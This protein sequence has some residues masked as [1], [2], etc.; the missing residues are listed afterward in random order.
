MARVKNLTY[1][2]T[3]KFFNCRILHKNKFYNS[4]EV[5][6]HTKKEILEEMEELKAK[7]RRL[8]V[9]NTKT[10]LID[11]DK[12][13][14]D[15]LVESIIIHG[16]EVMY[17]TNDVTPYFVIRQL[18]LHKRSS[19]L[20]TFR[21]EFTNKEVT[22][23]EQTSMATEVIID[24]P[25][26]IPDDNPYDILFSLH[27]L[28]LNVDKVYISFPTIK[29]EDI[30]DRH[31]KYYELCEDGLYHVKAN[32]RFEYFYHIQNSL[33]LWKM[34]IYLIQENDKYFIEM[35]DIIT[36]ALDKRNPGRINQSEQRRYEEIVEE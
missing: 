20:Y 32:E 22:N 21:E 19:V 10:Y 2:N 7:S 1:L 4:I 35:Y 26:I 12:V 17:R 34:N 29:P 23:I 5:N 16:G 8:P 25:V 11:K 24:C 15:G 33:S 28:K 3:D 27:I 6:E 31:L 36:E 18:A 14:D 13:E 9:R 30:K